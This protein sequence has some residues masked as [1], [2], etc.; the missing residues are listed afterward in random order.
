MATYVETDPDSLLGVLTSGCDER[1]FLRPS[2]N[3][4]KYHLN[5]VKFE[6]LLQ[7]GSCTCNLLTPDG[8]DVATAYLRDYDGV[9][10]A[11]KAVNQA[12]RLKS[13]F[14]DPR[15]A[16]SEF[17]VVFGPSGSDM[18]Y[19]PLLFMTMF[20]PGKE[21]VNIVTCPE[22]LGSGS[23]PAG[24][25]KYYANFN[26][27]GEIV[28]LNGMVCEK[29]IK[30]KCLYLNARDD[31]HGAVLERATE[32][33][34][35]VE[36]HIGQSPVVVNLVFGS[37]SGIEDDLS[38]IDSL[39]KKFGTDYT[40]LMFCVDMCQFRS[41]VSLLHELMAKNGNYAAMVDVLKG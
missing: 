36:K 13:L 19:V 33:E 1:V 35:M 6:N 26:Q 22:E 4:N 37:K 11:T 32:I 5:P 18:M 20:N 23:K 39:Q 38:V 40:K 8:Y 7:R 30:T 14:Q 16:S 27:K 9:D 34:A 21:I 28:E 3:A 24:E 31:D 17:D 10:Y 25:I 29:E 15:A 12:N 41:E 2:S